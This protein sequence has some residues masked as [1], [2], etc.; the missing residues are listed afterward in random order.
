MS[1]IHSDAVVVDCHNDFI[2]LLARER[3][4]GRNDSLVRR[5]VP[6]LRKGGINVQVAPIFIDAEFLPEG[7]LRR[8]LLLIAHLREEVEANPQDVALCLT[9][10]D[11][12]VAVAAEKLALVLALEGS[13]AI[14]SN[15][16]LFETMFRLGVRMASFTWMGDTG[17]AG[18]SEDGDPGLG[19][20]ARGLEALR[21]LEGLGIVMDVSHLSV[22]STADVVE[23]ATRPLVASHSGARAVHDHHRN[24]LDE[25]VKGIAARGGVI[26][27]PA[28]IPAFIDPDNPSL[29]RVVDHIVHIAETAG[30]DH[31][32]IGADFCKEYFDEAY[33]TYEELTYKDIDLR[34]T[35]S[36]LERPSDMPALTDSL[37]ARGFQPDEI[38]K[39]LGENF[40]R[41]FRDV[42]GNSVA[43][44]G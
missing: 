8:T 1:T 29:D 7:A 21:Q 28:A 6:Q 16:E 36:G 34:A 32:G 14:A 2:L 12:D 19:L 26:G 37:E 35:I 4:L 23:N 22:R 10:E 31:V 3:S 42:M 5:F 38:H 30:I 9:G 24:L 13:H 44:P 18:G 33:A 11:I 27:V 20:S 15:I 39:I 43:E 41:V 17:L 25:H 40:L